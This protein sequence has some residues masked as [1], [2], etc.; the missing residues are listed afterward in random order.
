MRAHPAW[1]LLGTALLLPGI[2]AAD[3]A[4][5]LK[6]PSVA[7]PALLQ[8]AVGDRMSYTG[9][10]PA[11]VIPDLCLYRYRVTTTSPQ[12]QQH[13]D[14]ALGYYYS[15]VW[16]EAARSF[17]TALRYDPDCAFAYW[18][19]SKSLEKWG[20]PNHTAALQKAQALLPRA[21]HREQL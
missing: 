9:L 10:A 5:N 19:L 1:P 18:G 7:G 11:K 12:C 2:A 4:P 17:E 16:M 13:V 6:P 21:G 14:Q 3:P 20:K 15:Y 8:A